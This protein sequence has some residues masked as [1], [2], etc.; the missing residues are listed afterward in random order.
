[1]VGTVKNMINKVAHEHPN[2]W[3]QYLGYILWALR[4]LPNETTGIPPWVRAF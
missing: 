3:Y 1:M 2:R 4:E